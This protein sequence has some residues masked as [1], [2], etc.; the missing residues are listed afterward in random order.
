MKVLPLLV[1]TFTMLLGCVENTTGSSNSSLTAN[2]KDSLAEPVA[3][4]VSLST[5]Q[6]P[7]QLRKPNQSF[8][9]V[10]YTHLTLPTNR[11]V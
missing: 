11:E 3:V 7:Y 8:K 10:S 6:F 9:S 2:P 4:S 1:F 5:Y